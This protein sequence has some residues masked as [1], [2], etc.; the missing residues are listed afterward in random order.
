[1][2]AEPGAARTPMLFIMALATL[3]ISAFVTAVSMP[4]AAAAS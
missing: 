4:R 3:A 2:S 1:M